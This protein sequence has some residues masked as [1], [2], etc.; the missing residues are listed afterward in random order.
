LTIILPSTGDILAGVAIVGP[1]AFKIPLSETGK[2]GVTT[3]DGLADPVL[4][5]VGSVEGLAT[6][7]PCDTPDVGL[8]VSIL[9]IFTDVPLVG[10]DDGFWL[11]TNV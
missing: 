9:N 5:F 4:C 11:A 1:V 2:V 7:E 8:L 3:L 6:N 10:F